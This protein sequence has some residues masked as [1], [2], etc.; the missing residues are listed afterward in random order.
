MKHVTVR[1]LLF[2]DIAA[3]VKWVTALDFFARYAPS[4]TKLAREL[5]R[6][7]KRSDLVLVAEQKKPKTVI[8]VVW[9][10]AGG[11]FGRSGFLRMLAV[12]SEQQH[13]GVGSLLLKEAEAFTENVSYDL[14]FLVPDF[15]KDVQAMAEAKGYQQTGGVPD[16]TLQDVTDLIYRKRFED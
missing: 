10:Q 16:Y 5:E 3:L 13:K 9:C 12:S 1:P 11:A 7:L 2:G 6:A 15:A 4:E 8:A 14:F